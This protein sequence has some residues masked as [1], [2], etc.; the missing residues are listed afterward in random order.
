MERK[1]NY[2]VGLGLILGAGI[3]GGIAV[4]GFAITNNPAYFEYAAIGVALGIIFGAGLESKFNSK[5]NKM[6]G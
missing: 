5:K 4:I 2:Y 6:K 3:G 1:K